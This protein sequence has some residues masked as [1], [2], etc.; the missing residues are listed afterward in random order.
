M[1]YKPNSPETGD[2]SDNWLY[3]HDG[4]YY[5]YLLANTANG[6]HNISMAVSSDGVHWREKGRIQSKRHGANWMGSGSTWRSPTHDRDSKFFMNFSEWRGPR[7][8]IFFAEST[9]LLKW[10]RLDDKYEFK[11][12]TR[13]Y[14]QDG[15]WDCIYTIPRPGGALFGYWTATPKAETGGRFGFGQTSDGITW[16]ALSPPKVY[17]VGAGEVGAVEKIGQK[18]YMMFGTRLADG[19]GMVTLVADRPEGPFHAAKKNFR[20]LTGHTYFS[21]FFPTPDGVLV[22]HPSRAGEPQYLAP[23]KSAVVDE[24]GTLRLGWWKG[25]EKLKHEPI[26]VKLPVG[27]ESDDAP[28]AILENRFDADRGIILEGTIAL[29]PP[30]DSQRRGLY[31]ECGP[32]HGVGILVAS[33]GAVELGTMKSDATEFK[34]VKGV[35]REMQFG[36]PAKF[37]L[38]LKYALIEFYLDDILIECYGLPKAATG[39]V[40]LIRGTDGKSIG[41]LRAWY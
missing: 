37:R 16:E 27:A 33:G 2:L 14:E 4:T 11:Q 31:V 8:T 41:G 30:E 40:G 9:D 13:W 18:Y 21:R 34:V 25:N 23:L 19:H 38:L 35:N 6:S 22:N 29:P 3:L 7:Q 39:R 1:F 15:R 36:R 24:E 10:K 28:V 20:V 32:G 17:G 12:D 26:E 5:L